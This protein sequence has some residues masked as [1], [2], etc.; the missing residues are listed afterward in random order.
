MCDRRR[1]RFLLLSIFILVAS[2]AGGHAAWGGIAA[3]CNYD[4]LPFCPLDP[5]QVCESGPSAGLECFNDRDCPN[6]ACIATT[7][8]PGLPRVCLTGKNKENSC[9]N[10]SNCPGS[11]CV[12]AF[13][14]DT[15]LI[16]ATLT[17]IVDDHGTD[18]TNRV[19]RPT[20][21]I[22]LEVE[23][24]GHRAM[25][26]Q[27]YIEIRDPNDDAD[28][29]EAEFVRTEIGLIDAIKAAELN[30]PLVMDSLLNRLL[31]RDSRVSGDPFG[32]APAVQLAEEL[33][34][35][36]KTTGRPV[37]IG[38]PE[39]VNPKDYTDQ[40]SNQIA[41]VVRLR[42]AIRFVKTKDTP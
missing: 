38:V 12:I 5:H 19:L 39:R 29:P 21:T 37:I 34:R 28:Y 26:A 41:S 30:N 8:D 1:N 17:L 16:R 14:E 42:I 25:L 33:R 27:T 23:N 31:F 20:T 4:E 7:F 35:I 6:S 24:D 2:L 3:P 13:I 22:L 9:T 36:Y 18:L 40:E 10:D 32:L 11:K 15:P